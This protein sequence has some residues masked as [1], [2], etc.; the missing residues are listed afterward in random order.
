[1][2]NYKSSQKFVFFKADS[3]QLNFYINVFKLL[4]SIYMF[5]SDPRVFLLVFLD[6]F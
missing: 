3:L 5:L 2:S 4:Q 1:M 6:V